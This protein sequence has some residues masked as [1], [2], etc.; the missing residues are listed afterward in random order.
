MQPVQQLPAAGIRQ[1]PENGVV[2]HRRNMQPFG[3]L[4][5]GKSRNDRYGVCF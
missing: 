4:S 1:G 3:Y 5:R 2:I